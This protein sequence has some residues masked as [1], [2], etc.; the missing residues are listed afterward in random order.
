VCDFIYLPSGEDAT[1][2]I[3]ICMMIHRE[4]DGNIGL[5]IR[6][7]LVTQYFQ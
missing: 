6:K 3:R 5:A 1:R 7:F 2:L 4:P